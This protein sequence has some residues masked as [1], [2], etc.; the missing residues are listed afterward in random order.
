MLENT[1]E[2]NF[3]ELK[4]SDSLL[5]NRNTSFNKIIF[6]PRSKIFD[7]KTWHPWEYHDYLCV[8]Y[9]IKEETMTLF[10]TCNLYEDTPSES[11]WNDIKGNCIEEQLEIATKVEVK[12]Q[13][14]SK[15]I[16]QYEAS[17]PQGHPGSRAPGKC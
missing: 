13:I 9:E 2:I 12:Q 11:N 3:K 8:S 14:R 7:N 1:K 15:L 5:D 17:H 4:L 16:E 10:L 6:S